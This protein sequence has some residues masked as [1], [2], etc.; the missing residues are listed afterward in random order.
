MINLVAILMVLAKLSSTGLLKATVLKK[1]KSFNP[2]FPILLSAVEF[3]KSVLINNIANL[4][5][6]AK[7]ASLCLLKTN[8]F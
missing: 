6:T 4:I 3:F 5:V 7:L 2:S 1:K 8:L